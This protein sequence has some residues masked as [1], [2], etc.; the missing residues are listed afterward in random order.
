MAVKTMGYNANGPANTTANTQRGPSESVWNPVNPGGAGVADYQQDP[1]LGIQ[2]F[3]DFAV[4]GFDP[5]PPQGLSGWPVGN[6]QSKGATDEFRGAVPRQKGPEPT[7]VIVTFP[8]PS[9][10]VPVAAHPAGVG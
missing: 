5:G 4:T 9:F 3:D 1:R 6:A 8:S 2:F 7:R 10:S